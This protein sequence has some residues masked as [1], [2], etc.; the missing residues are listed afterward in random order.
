MA[1]Q[2]AKLTK[3]VVEAAK[4]AEKDFIIWDSELAGFGCKVTPKGRKTY[5]TYY[6]TKGGQQRR[7]AIGVHGV[8]TADEA[9]KEAQR[10][11]REASLG[12]D[13]SAATQSQ[14]NQRTFADF[15]DEYME[16]HANV[17]K[18]VRSA[19]EDRR[20][21]ENHLKPKF[22]KKKIG[23]IQRADVARFHHDMREKPG[24]ANRCIALLSKMFN[25]AKLWG[26]RPD[27]SNPT[28]HIEKYKENKI[29]R[30]LSA[31]ELSRLGKALKEGEE[32]ETEKPPAI[33]AIRLL[34][35]TGCRKE[36]VLTLKWDYID[37][38]N[39]CL[40]LPDSKTGAKI[41]YLNQP[42]IDVLKSTTKVKD[43]PYVIT[44]QVSKSHL[45]NI[46]KP[47]LRIRKK[48]KLPDLRLHD[49]RHSF[50][51]IGA[52]AGLGLPLVGALLG[53]KET[54]TTQR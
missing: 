38:E 19:D 26:Y 36:E 50:A 14:R 4:P 1:N 12:G 27:N 35:F 52:N 32:L 33:A 49:L 37:F 25:L 22:G 7:P 3:R 29:E 16:R 9:R 47:W 34:I 20:N 43:N 30:F 6:R 18:K 51:S 42:A 2:K 53:H 23:D 8:L 24:A 46:S 45:V 15:A 13:P 48:A 5:F 31:K 40:R 41:V 21:L 54:N 17:K 11:L 39:S 44:G 10:G 28:R